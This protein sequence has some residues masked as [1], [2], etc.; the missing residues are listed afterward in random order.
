[1]S[2][3]ARINIENL[4]KIRA[5]FQQAE[6][7]PPSTY[8]SNEFY[9]AEVDN[10]FMKI[11]NF[12]GREDYIGKPGDFVTF[13]F[14]GVQ[15]LIVR[16]QTGTVRAFSNTC[17]HRGTPVASGEG[18]CRAF[19][20]PYHG[21]TYDLQGKLVSAPE[22]QR[23]EGFCAADNGLRPIRLETWEGFMFVTFDPAAEPLLR[24][25]G[26]LPDLLSSYEFAKMK[27]VRRKTYTMNCNWKLYVENAMEAYHV[28]MVHMHTLQK[29][30]R[31]APPEIPSIGN[32]V[33]YHVKH[34]GSRALLV[35]ETGF[36][37]IKSLRGPAAEGSYFVLIY[38]STMFGVTIDCMWWLELRPL[39]PEK[40]ELIVGSSF[41]EETV[42]RADFEEVIQ[43]YYKRWDLSIPEDNDISELQQKGVRSP[44]AEPGRFSHLEPLVHKIDNWIVDRVLGVKSK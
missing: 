34:E 29:L 13:E 14:V 2:A 22:M 21:W 10:I 38:P 42:A 8:F 41:P 24:Y 23:T 37:R 27:T 36:P 7:L 25:L 44:Y 33:G 11:W 1:M 17:R 19:V 43:K 6:T 9:Q 26:D 31:E 40:T 12:V 4:S 3:V 32:W 28:P 16:D 15:I 20:C 5:P 39:G 30:K 35:G 18:S